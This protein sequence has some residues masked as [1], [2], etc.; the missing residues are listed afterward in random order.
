MQNFSL[1][2]SAFPQETLFATISVL[3]IIEHMKILALV[4]SL[5]WTGTFYQLTHIKNALFSG[6]IFMCLL[7]NTFRG[8]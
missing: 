8:E 4:I 1:L 2:D 6:C 5:T 3:L 7:L